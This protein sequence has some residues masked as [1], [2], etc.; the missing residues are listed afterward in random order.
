MS[1]EILMPQ[2]GESVVEGTVSRW[3][4]AEGEPVRQ[5]QPLLQITTDKV[6][7]ELPAPASGILL[8]ILVPEGETVAKGTVLGMIGDAGRRTRDQGSGVR[9]QE[10]E[11]VDTPTLG[12]ISPVVGRLAGELG[13]DLTRV[14]GTGAGGRITK[15]DVLA[16]AA[17]SVPHAP[18]AGPDAHL[19]VTES[20]VPGHP[21]AEASQPTDDEILPLAPMRRAI[22]RHMV[23]SKQTAP[24]ATTV[25]EADMTLVVRRASGCGVSSSGRA[26]GSPSHP[27]LSRLS[28]QVSGPSP[29]PTAASAKTRC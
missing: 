29:R 20:L 16:Y 9:E 11:P 25:M 10:S 21:S 28:S 15:K 23:L 2:L 8:R 5:D 13:V 6:D 22:A 17:A 19:P 12:F 14:V 7:T 18:L 4:I 24:H 26:S 1:S 27:S 3:L